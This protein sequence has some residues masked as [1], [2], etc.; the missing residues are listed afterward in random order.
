MKRS[1]NALLLVAASVVAVGAFA[2]DAAAQ[3]RTENVVYEIDGTAYEGYVAVNEGIAG[4]KPLVLVIHDWD[5][6][7]DYEER[8]AQM[9]AELGYAAFAVDLYGQGVR[10]TTTQESQAQSGALYAD[11]AAMRQRLEAGLAAAREQAGISGDAAVAIGYCFGGAAALEMARAGVDLDGF[12]SFHG[13]LG[14]PEG[15]T[16][17]AVSGEV[18]ILHG[19]NDPVAPMSDVAA[20]A[21][22]LD[23]ADVDF[24]MEIY[25]GAKHAFTVW[26]TPDSNSS[27][28]DAEADLASWNALL[29]FLDD[30][31]R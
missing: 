9:L 6:L 7:G 26:G 24:S 10:P 4:D 16:W 25:G 23:E 1:S 29:A 18:L 21:T 17:D 2:G 8:R 30:R 5:G 12:V 19:S 28:Y 27:G 14:A 15:A 22:A 31:I 20:L 13:G 3:I 11:R